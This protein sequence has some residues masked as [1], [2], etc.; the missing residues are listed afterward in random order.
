MSTSRYFFCHLQKTGGVALLRRLAHQFPEAALYPAAIDG[1]PPATTVSVDHLQQRWA[2]RRDEIRVVCG[3]FPLCTTELLGDEFETFTVLRDP[4]ERVLS[5]L[6]HYW[7]AHPDERHRDLAEIYADPMRR[8]LLYENHMV[9]MLSLNADEMTDGMYTNIT[10]DQQRLDQA[11]ANLERIDVVGLLCDHAGFCRDLEDRF[12]W[13]LGPEI[14]ANV[15]EPADAS[16][17]LR[18]R[19]AADNT[20]DIALYE[21]AERL[22]AAR[23]SAP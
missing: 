12:G 1:S 13:D 18:A 11:I 7:R 10:C 15:T 8:A 9:R 19:I 23:T 3:H 6:R 14:V 5:S 4:V 2:A 21:A 16:E 17:Q 20:F 22:V